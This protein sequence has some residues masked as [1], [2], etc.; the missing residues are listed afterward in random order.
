MNTDHSALDDPHNLAAAILRA[1]AGLGTP[2]PENTELE[3]AEYEPGE[4]PWGNTCLVYLR[5]GER[6]AFIGGYATRNEA[7][8]IGSE[9]LTQADRYFETE[10]D[11]EVRNYCLW[12]A[13]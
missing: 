10:P 2:P 6:R 7:E 5:R 1:Q 9:A 8:S 4:L 12:D 3:I 11:P 13:C